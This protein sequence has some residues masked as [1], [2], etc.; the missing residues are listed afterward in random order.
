MS[1]GAYS[2]KNCINHILFPVF[3]VTFTNICTVPR[4]YF[5]NDVIMLFKSVY[6]R[7]AAEKCK[8]F[9]W[10][11]WLMKD[12]LPYHCYPFQNRINNIV[13]ATHINCFSIST[14]YCS[15]LLLHCCI[16]VPLYCFIDPFFQNGN[17]RTKFFNDIFLLHFK[18]CRCHFPHQAHFFEILRL[19][20][21][22]S[23]LRY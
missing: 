16:N 15:I 14:L 4:H 2:C 6:P 20:S 11:S 12:V 9:H 5:L 18:K 3:T 17:Q 13:K 23:V 22:N 7:D 19:F 1:F 8:V 21:L 10:I